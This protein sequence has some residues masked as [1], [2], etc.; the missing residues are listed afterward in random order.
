MAIAALLSLS[1]NML[2]GQTGLLSFGHAIYSGLGAFCAIH[3]LAR[4]DSG[5]HFP[6]TLLPIIGGLGGLAFAAAFGLISARCAGTAFAMITLAMSELISSSALML[7]HFFGGEV[8]VSANRVTGPPLM[9]IDYGSQLQVYYLIT[10]WALASAAAICAFR[11]TPLDRIANALRDNPERVAFVGYSP[12]ALRYSMQLVAGFF[13][14]IA[15]GL[16]AINY[17]IVTIDSVDPL[18]SGLIMLMTVIGGAGQFV[19]P[20]VGAILVTLMQT[21]VSE[22]TKAWPFYLGLLFLCVIYFL[23][24]GVTS[25]AHIYRHLSLRSWR[26]LSPQCAMAAAVLVVL[27]LSVIGLVEMTYAR[28]AG[29]DVAPYFGVSLAPTTWRPWLVSLSG[30]ALTVYLLKTLGGRIRAVWNIE[31]G[32]NAS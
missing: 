23:P 5:G 17:E 12:I 21:V 4:I 2:Y 10:G 9:G 20:I 14:G 27:V 28:A 8:G 32:R 18:A 7:P 31:A 22:Y 1:Y 19:G 11:F 15:G 25:V 30:V 6:V 26:R 29:N 24:G 16:A 13:A 3:A